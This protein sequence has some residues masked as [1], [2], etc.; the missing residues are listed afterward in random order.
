MN[1]EHE[2][3]AASAAPLRQQVVF[4]S[5]GSPS[6]VIERE[7]STHKFLL[8]LGQQIGRPSVILC[9]SA[10]WES[11]V[12]E[13][14]TA[15][16]PPQIYDFGGFPQE[17][18]E[19]Q[20]HP[21]GAPQFAEHVLSLL[22]EK[23]I[24]CAGNN[25]HGLDHGAWCPLK[26]MYPDADIPVVQLSL[27]SNLDAE[28]HRDLGEALAP[29]LHMDNERVLIVASGGVTHNL[30]DAFSRKRDPRPAEWATSF[31]SWVEGVV[32]QQDGDARARAIADFESHPAA[33]K[34]HPRTEHF[35][36]LVVAASIPGTGK[37]EKLHDAF[38]W[39]FSL[40]AYAFPVLAQEK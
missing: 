4:V 35:L 2:N 13:V 29:L 33:S 24:P 14:N 8:S 3:K 16:R 5:H 36:P 1:Q 31:A 25:E 15:K 18:Y 26:L 17:M 30:R 27:S 20:Y 32:T 38:S 6:M 9:I 34:A 21:P 10:H 40:A 12:V 19:L 7:S 28:F 22:R 37:A 23:N 39:E 11:G